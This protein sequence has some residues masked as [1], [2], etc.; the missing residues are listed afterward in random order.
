MSTH[1]AFSVFFYCCDLENYVKVTK[2]LFVLCCVPNTYPRKFGKN[3]TTGSQ[4]IVQTRKCHA[5]V[6]NF[7][8]STAVTLKIR[9]R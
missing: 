1:R 3:P 8:F 5:S 4:D 2:I 6:T 7:Q 9:S